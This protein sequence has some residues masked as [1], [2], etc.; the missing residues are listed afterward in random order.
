MIV[1]NPCHGLV[2]YGHGGLQSHDRTPSTPRSVSAASL[3][4]PPLEGPS[5]EEMSP[6]MARSISAAVATWSRGP[7][8]WAA[9]TAASVAIGAVVVTVVAPSGAGTAQAAPSRGSAVTRAALAPALVA[10][11]G[12]SVAFSEQ[13]AE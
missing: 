3:E 10:G 13:E 8:R 1:Q 6:S 7:R 12:A 2:Q 5:L 11:R 4:E 9:T